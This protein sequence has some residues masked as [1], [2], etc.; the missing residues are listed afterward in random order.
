MSTLSDSTLCSPPGPTDVFGARQY[1]E[2]LHEQPEILGESAAIERLRTQ[3]RRLGPHFRTVLLRG[4]PGT[5]KTL[6]ARA[7]H[8]FSSHAAGPFVISK[9]ASEDGLRDLMKKAHR[10]TLYLERIDGMTPDSQA[11]LL[12][13]LQSRERSRT[14]PIVVHGLEARIIA[15]TT[16][17]LR[18]LA[19]AG[20]FR[21]DLYARLATV[22]IALPPLRERVEDIPLLAEHFM[23]RHARHYGRRVKGLSA[24]ALEWMQG[25]RW[26]GNVRELSERMHRAVVES[27]SGRIEPEHMAVPIPIPQ[28]ASEMEA[29]VARSGPARLQEVVEQHVFQVLKGCAGNKVKAAELLGISRSTLYRMLETGLQAD[30]MVRLR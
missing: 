23:D 15:S 24:E 2:P 28:T 6:A 18:V 7:L 12:V 5:G 14:G 8:G 25:Y 27:E 20:R 29:S 16:E 22:E 1:P 3:L 9:V 19:A 21:Q 26:P 4:E 17:D 11:E 30:K 10:G 13:T